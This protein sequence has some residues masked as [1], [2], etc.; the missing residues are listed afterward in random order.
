VRPDP[1]DPLLEN[2]GAHLE[3]W[4]PLVDCLS[5]GEESGLWRRRALDRD[6]VLECRAFGLDRADL[7]ELICR[8]YENRPRAAILQERRDL[9][10]RQRGVNRNRGGAGTEDRVIGHRPLGPVLRKDRDSVARLDSE[11]VEPK[12]QRLDRESEVGP[13]YRAPTSA[14]FGEKQVRFPGSGGRKKN[15]AER[16]R[17]LAHRSLPMSV[18]HPTLCPSS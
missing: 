11:R 4:T 13:R 3:R 9:V 8:R 15:V 7:G 6:D 1:S 2:P 16:A 17:S 18:M 14:G 5:E 12:R 10:G